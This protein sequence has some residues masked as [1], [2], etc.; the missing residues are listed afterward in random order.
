MKKKTPTRNK[1]TTAL[2]QMLLPH[3]SASTALTIHTPTDLVVQERPLPIPHQPEPA[4][5]DLSP[6]EVDPVPLPLSPIVEETE[7]LS[8][9]LRI[10]LT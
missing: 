8:N 1:F 6:L 3:K 2:I 10:G 9:F 4:I 5:I 7:A